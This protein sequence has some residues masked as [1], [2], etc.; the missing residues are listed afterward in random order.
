MLTKVLFF[1]RSLLFLFLLFACGF[2]RGVTRIGTWN[3]MNMGAHKPEASIR[4]MAA[5]LKDFDIVALQEI[6]TAPGGAQAVARLADALS[7]EGA[8]WDYCISDPTTAVNPGESERYA[9]IWKKDKVVFTGKAFLAETF[10]AALSREPYLAVFRA[11][12]K[13]MTLVNF[14]ALPRKKQ[15]ERELKYLKFF[16]DSL[17]LVNPVFLGDFNCPQA[18]SV[19]TPLKKKGYRPALTGQKTTLRQECIRNDCLASEYDN[20]FYPASVFK[21]R[22]AGVVPFYRFL[23][24]DMKAA[25]KLSDHLPVYVDL[26]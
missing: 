9:Y 26:E 22:K 19:F 5:C 2:A 6:G 15:P 21:Q 20:I 14:H 8:P 25:R 13:T 23:Q 12:G 24:Y 18:H 10:G 7:R 11:G 17:K 16:P 1:R 4:I 3:L